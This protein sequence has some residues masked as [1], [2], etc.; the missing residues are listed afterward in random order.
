MNGQIKASALIITKDEARKLPAC[1]NALKDFDEIIV[2][3]SNSRDGTPDIAAQ[4][5]ASVYNF[6]WNG[7]YPKKRQWCLENI[8]TKHEWIFFCDADEIVPQTLI[9]EIKATLDPMPL[10]AGFFVYGQYIMDGKPLRYGLRNNKIILINKHKMYYPHVDDLD[11]AGMGEIEGHYQPVPA[12]PRSVIGQLKTPLLHEAYANIAA[13]DFKHQKYATWAARM[14]QKK[15][16]PRDPVLWRDIAKK[17]MRRNPL[18][19]HIMFFYSYILRL[20]FL[21]GKAGHTH[22]RYRYLYERMIQRN[23]KTF[24]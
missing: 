9:D 15:A 7:A 18:R 21:D 6:T 24:S 23:L 13:W 14:T 3:D 5:G 4:N 1:I 2:V 16:W 19:P 20:G 22:A 12:N 17:L 11:I 10:Q 8:S